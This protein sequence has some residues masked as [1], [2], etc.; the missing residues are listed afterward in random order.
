MLQHD[1]AQRAGLSASTPSLPL[2]RKRPLDLRSVD[3]LATAFTPH[4]ASGRASARPS[5][6]AANGAQRTV[7]TDPARDGAATTSTIPPVGRRPGRARLTRGALSDLGSTPCSRAHLARYKP[8]A[9][10]AR[11]HSPRVHLLRHPPSG[12]VNLQRAQSPGRARSA[13][14]PG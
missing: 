7:N 1:L 2:D 10:A 11:G 6:S 12:H 5:K 4:G 8:L 3:P 9:S 13:S 14:V